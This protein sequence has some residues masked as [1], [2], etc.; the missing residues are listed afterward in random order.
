MCIQSAHAMPICIIDRYRT[1]LRGVLFYLS[2]DARFLLQGLVAALLQQLALGRV[3]ELTMI[4]K[5]A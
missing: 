2:F 4:D 5:H 3:A 1:D